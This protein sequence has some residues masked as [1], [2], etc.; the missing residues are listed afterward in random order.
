MDLYCIWSHDWKV[1]WPNK[2]FL[3][4]LRKSIECKT[5]GAKS[6]TSNRAL[7]HCAF[8]MKDEQLILF[9]CILLSH[10]NKA[11]NNLYSFIYLLYSSMQAMKCFPIIHLAFLDSSKSIKQFHW[12][13][14]NIISHTL[15]ILNR[16]PSGH[17]VF[18]ASPS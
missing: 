18:K 13:W 16:I 12:P 10:L 4:W 7:N 1:T 2:S 11:L 14:Y 15:P 17:R 6:I 9:Y 8:V 5:G 3:H